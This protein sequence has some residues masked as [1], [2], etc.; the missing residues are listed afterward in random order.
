[1]N[2]EQ[3]RPTYRQLALTFFNIISIDLLSLCDNFKSI[4]W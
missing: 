3:S 1:M 4:I 2:T